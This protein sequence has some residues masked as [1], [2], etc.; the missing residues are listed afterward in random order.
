M[1]VVPWAGRLE[2]LVARYKLQRATS[3]GLDPRVRGRVWVHGE[4]QVEIGDRVVFDA[5]LAPIELHSWRGAV[6]TIGD[7]CYVGGGTSIEATH[8]IR[9]EA[10]VHLGVFCKLMDNDFHPLVGNRH[11]RPTARPVIVGAGAE[12]RARSILLAGAH[13]E[14]GA[15]VG[16]GSV[17]QRRPPRAR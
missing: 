8:S 7:D 13:I 14:R 12:I 5:S 15:R 10:G 11:A 4:G 17:L 6:I 16:A 9:L 2:A 1:L 3:V